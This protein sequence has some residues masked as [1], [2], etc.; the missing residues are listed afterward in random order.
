MVNM[1]ATQMGIYTLLFPENEVT[2]QLVRMKTG[3]AL[4]QRLENRLGIM[5]PD[6][7]GG[8]YGL[9]PSAGGEALRSTTRGAS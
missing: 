6:F 3:L 7:S 1:R 8:H 2:G 5:G 4:V 9:R